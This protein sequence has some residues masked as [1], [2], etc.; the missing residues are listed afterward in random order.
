MF[1]D[2]L[3]NKP[4]CCWICT[5]FDKMSV[6]CLVSHYVYSKRLVNV[7]RIRKQSSYQGTV[8]ISEHFRKF[9]FDLL[10]LLILFH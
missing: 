5:K 1:V 8:G 6:S 9:R 7:E 4:S 10:V 3:R 2:C